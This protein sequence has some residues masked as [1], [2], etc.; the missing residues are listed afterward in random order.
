MRF[1]LKHDLP[2]SPKEAFAILFGEEY[3]KS[4]A[5]R[6]RIEKT[7]IEE[8]IQEARERG[9]LST[10]RAKEVMKETLGKAQTAAEE[11]RGR[12][13]FASQADLEKVKDAVDA[14]RVR[15]GTLE[16]SVFGSSTDA[17]ANDDAGGG[18]TEAGS[19]DAGGDGQD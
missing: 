15:L 7:L 18:S 6:S 9:D 5:A 8:T 13:D 1:E 4:V 14:M 3:S 16:E 17:S 2:K 11:A 10:D 12:L 19:D